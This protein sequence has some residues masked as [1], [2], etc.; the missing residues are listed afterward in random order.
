[1]N[2]KLL[3]LIFLLLPSVNTNAQS[4][5]LR[6]IGL[7]APIYRKTGINSFQLVY[8]ISKSKEKFRKYDRSHSTFR[9]LSFDTLLNI[10][11]TL[12]IKLSRDFQIL[13]MAAFGQHTGCLFNS[14]NGLEL[15]MFDSENH[16]RYAT[17][18]EKKWKYSFDLQCEATANG[19]YISRMTTK[20]NWEVTM[21]DWEGKKIWSKNISRTDRPFTLN[22]NLFSSTMHC[23]LIEKQKR[24]TLLK[25]MV[26]NAT[27]GTE[28][29]ATDFLDSKEIRSYDKSFLVQDTCL[30]IT[31]RSFSDGRVSQSQTGKPYIL[32]YLPNGQTEELEF[33]YAALA[34]TKF[35]W[36]DFVKDSQGNSYLIGETFT[37][38]TLG[39]YITKL[40]IALPLLLLES[41]TSPGS[42]Q[43]VT[44]S[45]IDFT[46]VRFRDVV[47]LPVG[48][49]TLGSPR[50]LSLHRS[51]YKTRG[52]THTYPLAR[53]AIAVRQSRY[54]LAGRSGVFFQDA[55]QV[56]KLELPNQRFMITDQTISKS[57][58]FVSENYFIDA[59]H[60]FLNS[61]YSFD[62][63][64]NEKLSDLKPSLEVVDIPK[65]Q[66][67]VQE[68]PH[69]TV[70]FQMGLQAN[71]PSAV[72]QYIENYLNYN[73]FN[74]ASGRLYAF[75][76]LKHYSV[77]DFTLHGSTY[78]NFSLTLVPTFRSR[79]RL[80]YEYAWTKKNKTSLSFNS[81]DTDF[82]LHRN[83]WGVVFNYYF[84]VK[85]YESI[86]L[87]AGL[88]SHNMTF[89]D[90][91]ATSTGLR[92]EI[93][94]AANLPAM[95]FDFVIG[96]DFAAGAA[97]SSGFYTP[98]PPVREIDLTGVSIGIRIT[99]FFGRFK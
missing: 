2:V 11:D 40:I 84:P 62:I 10:Q 35:I 26:L 86:F 93:G 90:F 96:V 68:K 4:I 95:D 87:G 15:D 75:V 85:G 31:G 9:L 34:H 64:I 38:G 5:K 14:K 37:S 50:F 39:G 94:Y 19:F 1:M 79:I 3:V 54:L 7:D 27:T 42:S 21:F 8:K 74:Q 88:L 69:T 92:L 44:G 71:D 89:E 78:F 20:R 32:K 98:I 24:S 29:T 6:D 22:I 63:K 58:M 56:R 46:K 33:N 66:K 59:R 49:D 73:G 47:Y 67:I 51:S 12:Q 61:S 25:S 83:S 28:I 65:A 81:V 76:P 72:N 70:S 41:I 77:S 45:L 17:S 55:G 18:L 60:S 82:D 48:N 43:T 16:R 36:E 57:S 52:F 23:L 91:H 80:L 53:Q 97:S 99:P 30:L 13:S